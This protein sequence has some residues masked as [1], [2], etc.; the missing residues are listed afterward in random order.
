M[1]GRVV[2]LVFWTYQEDE[3]D[4]K[5]KPSVIVNLPQADEHLDQF[6][7]DGDVTPSSG[8]AIISIGSPP[9]KQ[10]A[11]MS[12]F[13]EFRRTWA[14]RSLARQQAKL[15]KQPPQTE[16]Q[17]RESRWQKMMAKR[18]AQKALLAQAEPEPELPSSTPWFP[19]VSQ[20]WQHRKELQEERATHAAQARV[21][22]QDDTPPAPSRFR[23][24]LE[25][26][27]LAWRNFKLPRFASKS[28]DKM[29][30]TAE[31]KT[32]RFVIV[33]SALVTALLVFAVGSSFRQHR[34]HSQVVD[35]SSATKIAVKKTKEIVQSE[36]TTK[37]E[38][39]VA[40]AK[41]EVPRREPV[42]KA[43]PK[44]IFV[45][46]TPAPKLGLEQMSDA[47]IQQLARATGSKASVAEVRSAA[48]YYRAGKSPWSDFH[49]VAA[50]A[51]PPPSK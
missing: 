7:A 33:I 13:A 3:M 25:D 23:L 22:A 10:W 12:W 43:E 45:H 24:W 49:P 15:N 19:R 1:T 44:E 38:P 14:E 26:K 30:L 48:V 34:P 46:Q 9:R 29:P 21:D 42:A 6:L 41:E 5:I 39:V 4:S 2:R 18:A 50:P 31:A 32:R 51:A 11:I 40:K 37:A 8:T 20:W 16:E 28:P 35:K 36:P 27:R 17:I 47:E